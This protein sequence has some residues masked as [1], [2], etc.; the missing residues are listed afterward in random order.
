MKKIVLVLLLSLC[1]TTIF[2]TAT[3]A[4]ELP[5]SVVVN[6]S[7]LNF[8][9][10]QPF[11]DANGRTQIPAKYIGQ[12]LGATVTWEGEE[13]KA[14]FTFG[15][16]E[17]ILYI[18]EK[19]YEV[20]GETK[21]MDTTAI[22]K[23]G[24]TFVP[25]KYI[26][27]A[28]GANVKWDGPAGTVY[29][30]RSL[31]TQAEE[32]KDVA[33]GTVVN[34]QAEFLEALRLATYTLQP[35]IV[36]ECNNY[37][38]SDYDLENLG[39][40]KPDLYVGY[41]IRIDASDINNVAEVTATITYSQVFKVQQ[42]IKN[43]IALG[44]LSDEES[45]VLDKVKDIVLK[46][47]KVSMTD[48]EKE[49]AIHDYLVLNYKYDYDNYK[50]DT[51]PDESYTVYGLLIKG[52]GVCQAYAEATNLLLNSVGI[53]CK[54]VIGT[55]KGDSHGWN[56]VKL[57]DEYYMLDVTGDDPAP[58]K[59]GQVR[60]DYFNVTADQ[61]AIDHEWDS[62]NW[63]IANGTKYNYFIYNN[64]VVNNYN[65]FKQLV[66]AK[67]KQG[68][69]KIMVYINNYDKNVYDLQFVF[70]YYSGSTS[71]DCSV[72]DTINTPFEITLK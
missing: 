40:H 56:V 9:D 42:A 17:L 21:Q 48:Y 72:S 58:D 70:N 67:I 19:S 41:D 24:R 61:L 71:F 2:S 62:S 26:A 3:F 65:E 29:V 59:A 13:K 52:T 37:E 36:L 8:P 57:E 54:M 47:I 28:F 64:L 43:H 33:A 7:K 55:S 14:I 53:E 5:I 32:G 22:L 44:R 31:T 16:K 10:A 45:A 69:K 20:D 23:D 49:L 35:I 38:N 60:Y 12:A 30:N 15:S 18:G 50:N 25:A 66:I 46:V 63:P 27:E 34:N 39:Q 1:L 68:E 11:V 6:D 51:I 4:A